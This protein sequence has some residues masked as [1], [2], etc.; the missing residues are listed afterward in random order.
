MS[1]NH[2]SADE[3]ARRKTVS[4]YKS[5]TDNL[6]F[7]ESKNNSS[8]GEAAKRVRELKEEADIKALEQQTDTDYYNGLDCDVDSL[9]DK[10]SEFIN[11]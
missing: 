2:I 10:F 11:G 5:N 3:I 4:D 8:H 9:T 7:A 6:T 1:I